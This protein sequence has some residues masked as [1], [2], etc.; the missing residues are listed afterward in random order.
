MKKTFV[1]FEYIIISDEI[2]KQVSRFPLKNNS[3]L[4]CIISADVLNQG[5]SRN[6]KSTGNEVTL[7][8]GPLATKIKKTRN[9]NNS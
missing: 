6:Y 9:T 5:S 2:K 4:I 1:G 3:V 8:K 7:I